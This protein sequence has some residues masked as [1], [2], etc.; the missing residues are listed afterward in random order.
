MAALDVVREH[1]ASTGVGALG[2]ENGG[3]DAELLRAPVRDG[4]RSVGQGGEARAGFGFRERG[5]RPGALHSCADCLGA[6]LGDRLVPVAPSVGVQEVLVALR[7][8]NVRLGEGGTKERDEFGEGVRPLG[9]A[10]ALQPFA[11]C[12]WC[13]TD[14]VG[15]HPLRQGHGQ[16]PPMQLSQSAQI[17]AE[18]RLQAVVVSAPHAAPRCPPVQNARPG[19]RLSVGTDQPLW[20]GIVQLLAE[21]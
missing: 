1:E 18:L 19:H 17:R 11:D 2:A 21:G 9:E 13:C 5:G 14:L 10:A 20:R 8:L 16:M 6:L 7:Y 12:G 3:V 15:N 4:A